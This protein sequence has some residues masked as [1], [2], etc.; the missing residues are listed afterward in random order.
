MNKLERMLSADNKAVLSARAKTA[1]EDIAA[2]STAFIAQL[3]KEKRESIKKLNALTDIG[4]DESTSLRV[5]EESFDAAHWIKQ[6]HSL[7]MDIRLK[8]IEIKVANE[9]HNEW[10]VDGNETND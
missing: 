3:E 8:E 5:V 10:M 4:P 1:M 9:I 6:I 7:K 2:E